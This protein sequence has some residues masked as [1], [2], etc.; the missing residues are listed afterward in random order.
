MK[1]SLLIF[2]VLLNLVLAAGLLLKTISPEI[3]RG[4]YLEKDDFTAMLSDV[5]VGSL[6]KH[7]PMFYR[8]SIL[9]KGI[10]EP[11]A[12]VE[13]KNRKETIQ[14]GARDIENG[15]TWMPGSNDVRF[16]T[17]EVEVIIKAIK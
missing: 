8:F 12:V 13:Y 15:I 10:E 4:K 9:Q 17:P 7:N 6:G 11:L 14:I 2:S 1:T 16:V 5:A 3:G